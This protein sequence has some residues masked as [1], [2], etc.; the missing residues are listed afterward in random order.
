MTGGRVIVLGSTG[1]NFAAGMSGGIA[2]VYD[3]DEDFASRCNP[4]LVEL[5]S[6]PELDEQDD[7][8]FLEQV[9]RLHVDAT[10][11]PRAAQVLA[12]WT[13]NLKRWIRVMPIEFKKIMAS[14]RTP[15]ETT[16]VR[17]TAVAHG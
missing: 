3:E 12:D 10:G 16:P 7:E 5:Q 11:S 6:L 2:Y 9:L 13:G 4:A 8:L 17:K 15:A 1:R 14:S